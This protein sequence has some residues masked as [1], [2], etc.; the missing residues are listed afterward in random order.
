M[1]PIELFRCM[2]DH[3]MLKY[4]FDKLEDSGGGGEPNSYP[5]LTPP[6]SPNLAP[7]LPSPI[8]LSLHQVN[9]HDEKRVEFL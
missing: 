1:N 7:S 8:P 9:L 5:I 2:D 3:Y 6:P 4:N